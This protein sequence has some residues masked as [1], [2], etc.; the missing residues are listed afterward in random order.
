MFSSGR[1]KQYHVDLAYGDVGRYVFVPGD[2]GR[3]ELIASFF[4]NTHKVAEHREYKTYTGDIDGIKVSVCST[5]IG[6]PSAAIAIE[7]L[8]RVGA[9]T[10][11]RIGTAGPMQEFIKEGDLV[12]G[13]ASVRDEGTSRQYMPLEFPAVADMNVSFALCEAARKLNKTYHAGIIQ[14]KDSFYGEVEPDTIPIAN[15][16]KERWNAWVKGGVLASEMEAAAIYVV[17]SI[18][19]LRAGCILNMGGSMEETIK[20]GIEAVKILAGFDSRK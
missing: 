2:P 10:F 19:K 13:T 12:I 1:E 15:T 9:D 17:S 3:V 6:S 18:R 16:L 4:D 7:E 5:G 14:S 8:S 20:V 11:I